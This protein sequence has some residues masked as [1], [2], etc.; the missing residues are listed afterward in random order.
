M[1]KGLLAVG[2]IVVLATQAM[3][4]G[5]GLQ[6]ADTAK[7]GEAGDVTAAAGVMVGQDVMFIGGRGMY[8]VAPNLRAFIDAGIIR[9]GG[10]DSDAESDIDFD[11]GFG[12]AGGVLFVLPFDLPVDAALRATVYKPIFP[13]AS[14]SESWDGVSID[15]SL[16]IIGANVAGVVSYDLPMLDGLTLYGTA[17]INVLRAEFEWSASADFGFGW[18]GVSYSDSVSETETGGLLGAGALY[19]VND[20]ISFYG[21]VTSYVGTD[22]LDTVGVGAGGRL[23]F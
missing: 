10:L 16:S 2:L 11:S 17:G 20:Q 3:G 13:D 18:G 15:Y 5:F 8:S 7:E 6:I 12:I 4:Q 22:Y 19:A 1:R 9:I 21:E 14:G 23:T